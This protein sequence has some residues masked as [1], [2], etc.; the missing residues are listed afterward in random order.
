[1]KTSQPASSS[2]W[3]NSRVVGIAV[4]IF[5]LLVVGVALALSGN[6]FGVVIGVVGLI[7]FAKGLKDHRADPP[8]IGLLTAWNRPLPYPNTVRGTVLLA[9]YFP[10][11]LDTI[12]IEMPLRHEDFSVQNI[13]SS[14]RVSMSGGVSVTVKPDETKLIDYVAAGKMDGVMQNIRN[15]VAVDTAKFCRDKSWQTIQQT[16]ADFEQFLKNEIETKPFGISIEKL[17]V[18]LSAPETVLSDAAQEARQLL[19][20][21]ANSPNT[22]LIS[23]PHRNGLKPSN[24]TRNRATGFRR[25]RKPSKKSNTSGSF[26]TAKSFAWTA[27]R[28]TF[29]LLKAA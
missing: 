21:R 10:F 5:L 4:L 1:M 26:A 7:M 20:R 27:T 25:L 19:Q 8:T 6:F 17:Q 3:G 12:E 13:L 22:R 23:S 16:S 24:S 18:H 9:N 14:D 29:W 15:I 11:C 28:I 2:S